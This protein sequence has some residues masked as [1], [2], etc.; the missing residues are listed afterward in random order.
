MEK[1]KALDVCIERQANR[2]T[3]DQKYINQLH[4]YN[5]LKDGT[6][7]LAE[8]LANIK[9][10]SAKEVFTEFEIVDVDAG[11]WLGKSRFDNDNKDNKK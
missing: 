7:K 11:K 5:Y 10:S 1:I 6:F 4:E 3:N 8:A 2:L 9:K